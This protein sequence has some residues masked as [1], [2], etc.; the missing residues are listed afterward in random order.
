[1]GA[2]HLTSA[3]LD[4]LLLPG[5]DG[6]GRLFRAFVEACPST[7]EPRLV[8][9]P[10]DAPLGYAELDQLIW[11][12]LPAG[13]PFAII[14]ES[15]SGPLAIRI[16]ARRPA[17]LVAIVLVGSFAEPSVR[18]VPAWLRPLIRSYLFRLPP[19]A[20]LIRHFAA[21]HNAPAAFVADVQAAMRLVRPDV[22][23]RRVHELLSVDVTGH[24]AGLKVPV[25][26]VAGKQDRLLKPHIVDRLKRLHPDLETSTLDAPHFILQRQSAAAAALIADFFE[27]H[28][29][30][31]GSGVQGATSS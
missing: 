7:I 30:A 6:T 29:P 13:R 24:L 27:R 5:L 4:T 18:W 23:A 14:A 25:L 11:R 9:Y 20:A 1:M 3:S 15:F 19:P 21:G 31:L 17:G 28:R 2:T 10:A 16:A 26:Y 8:A 12:A 22:L